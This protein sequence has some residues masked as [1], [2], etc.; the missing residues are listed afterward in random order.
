VCTSS[1]RSCS[2]DAPCLVEVR[3]KYRI[4]E[5]S[6]GRFVNQSVCNEAFVRV[7]TSS[8][9]SQLE[10]LVD[11]VTGGYGRR[12]SVGIEKGDVLVSSSSSKSI[13]FRD[14]E[15]LSTKSEPDLF[16]CKAV[17]IP[18]VPAPTIRIVESRDSGTDIARRFMS[19]LQR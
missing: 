19:R 3:C 16:R 4:F 2:D 13:P 9:G 7:G 15:M 1:I 6:F 12:H 10:N 14:A 11:I 8:K 17:D 5:P 18:Q